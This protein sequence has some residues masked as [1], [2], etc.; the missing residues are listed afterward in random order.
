MAPYE[1]GSVWGDAEPPL[2][3]KHRIAAGA[4]LGL[5]IS[6][7]EPGRLAWS[8]RLNGDVDFALYRL[9]GD[10]RGAPSFPV[11]RPGIGTNEG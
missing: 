10:Q 7:A 6:L 2:P 5:P 4:T 9:T 1:E 8:F 3:A 11:Q